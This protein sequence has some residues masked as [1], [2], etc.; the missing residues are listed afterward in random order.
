METEELMSEGQI[1]TALEVHGHQ[2][3]RAPSGRVWAEEVATVSDGMGGHHDA[4]AWVHA[5]TTVESMRDW[6]GY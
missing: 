5:P 6:L 2:W 1:I 4:T 3:H